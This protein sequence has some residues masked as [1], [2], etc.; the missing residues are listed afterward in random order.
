MK[1]DLSFQLESAAWPAFVVEAG[2]TIRHAN[3]AA[4]AFFGPKLEGEGLSL[5]AL[6][7][8]QIETAEQFLARWERSAVAVIP[9][10]YYGKGGTVATFATSICS[11]RDG[12]QRYIFQ[13]VKDQVA[14][15]VTLAVDRRHQLFALN[16]ESAPGGLVAFFPEPRDL[17]KPIP[18]HKPMV[19]DA[20]RHRI[21]SVTRPRGHA[22]MRLP[23][24][25]I[26]WGSWVISVG[27]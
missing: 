16:A 19:A 10:K 26:N 4:I 22:T 8:D 21:A 18:R 15:A 13:L 23:R 2:G 9:I 27:R 14:D 7:A 1:S 25:V 12:Q 5:S 3:Q 24:G 17:L 6:W 11:A 20:V